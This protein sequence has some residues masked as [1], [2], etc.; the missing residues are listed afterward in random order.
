[1][2]TKYISHPK[3][4]SQMKAERYLRTHDCS[5]RP[6]TEKTPLAA[7]Y[8]LRIRKRN[9][10]MHGIG[11]LGNI[12]GGYSR[13]HLYLRGNYAQDM[14]KDWMRVGDAFRESLQLYRK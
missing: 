10:F 6:V 4:L 12:S 3:T 14:R 11:S 9:P 5:G 8:V 7:V 2:V 13:I 1:M